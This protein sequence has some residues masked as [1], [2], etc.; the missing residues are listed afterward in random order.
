[1]ILDR[2]HGG[3]LIL[4]TPFDLKMIAATGY[5]NIKM[6]FQ[7][8]QVFVELATQVGQPTVVGRLKLEVQAFIDFYRHDSMIGQ[9]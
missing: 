5:T 1:E 9:T 2:V 4:I 8:M 6:R 3:T 7:L